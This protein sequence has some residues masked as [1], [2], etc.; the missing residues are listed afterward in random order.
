MVQPWDIRMPWAR[1]GPASEAAIS[2]SSGVYEI[3]DAG[4]TT[5]YIGAAGAR[6]LFGLRGRIA[7]H[8][9]SDVAQALQPVPGTPQLYRYEVTSAYLSR[10]V[11]VVAR[12]HQ[13][14]AMPPANLHAREYPRRMPYFGPG[15]PP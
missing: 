7:A 8:F 2:G 3:A 11:E 4:G 5:V 14:G 10:W 1:Y 6:D 12:H 9:Q 15:E 13:R